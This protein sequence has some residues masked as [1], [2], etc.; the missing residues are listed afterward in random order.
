VA[1]KGEDV[2]VNAFGA[3]HTE[4]GETTFIGRVKLAD[5][6][7]IIGKI[8]P[9]FKMCYVPEI[10]GKKELDFYNYEVFVV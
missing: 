10:K 2:P 3:G 4:H 9:S 1:A 6:K 5:G 8:H 7:L